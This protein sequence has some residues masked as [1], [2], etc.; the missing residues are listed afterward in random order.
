MSPASRSAPRNP[1][2]TF[3]HVFAVTPCAAG[4]ACF[5]IRRNAFGLA[6]AIVG[7]TP[8]MSATLVMADLRSRRWEEGRSADSTKSSR[9]ASVFMLFLAPSIVSFLFLSLSQ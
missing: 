3:A 9:F 1:L 2:T 7:T 8:A 5:N 4:F 6:S